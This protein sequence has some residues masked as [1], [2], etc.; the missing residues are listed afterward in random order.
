MYSKM[1]KGVLIVDKSQET[2]GPV[3]SK[4]RQNIAKSGGNWQNRSKLKDLKNRLC[5]RPAAVS[6]R[7]LPAGGS[8]SLSVPSGR[9]GDGSTHRHA[10]AS[11][12]PR[13]PGHAGYQ[14]Y[15]VLV[16]GFVIIRFSLRMN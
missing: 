11:R 7:W 4:N 3:G 1:S 14:L 6:A 15:I 16:Q 5:L 13:P 2:R 12:H 8:S 9:C 10:S